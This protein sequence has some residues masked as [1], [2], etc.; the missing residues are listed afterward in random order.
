MLETVDEETGE[1]IKTLVDKV[2]RHKQTR[3][4]KA[5]LASRKRRQEMR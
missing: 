1:V 4:K 5:I 3:L 2:R